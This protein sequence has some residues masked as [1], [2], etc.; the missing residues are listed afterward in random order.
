MDERWRREGGRGGR[1]RKVSLEFNSLLF[2][3]YGSIVS[4]GLTG[5]C[6]RYPRLY[7]KEGKERRGQWEARKRREGALCGELE[8]KV[9]G[10][11]LLL[12]EPLVLVDRSYN[13]LLDFSSLVGS[14]IISHLNLGHLC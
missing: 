9:E 5:R 4:R 12:P 2:A 7:P 1:E 6:H 8:L 3:F 10:L 13:G 11:T 14:V